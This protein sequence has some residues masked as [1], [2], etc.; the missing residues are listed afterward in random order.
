MKWGM[1]FV[2]LSSPTDDHFVKFFYRFTDHVLKKVM[3][4]RGKPS[5]RILVK[6]HCLIATNT[7]EKCYPGA[8]FFTTV[9]EPLGR[10]QSF[11]NFMTTLTI[12]GPPRNV[13]LASPVS[14]KV[15]RDYVVYTQIPYCEQEMLFYNQ[16]Q[17]NRLAIP[18]TM[19]VNNLSTTLQTVYNFCDVPMPQDLISNAIAMQY[20]THDR[21]KRKA[22]YDSRLNK[23]LESLGIDEVK[24]Q[25]TLTQ[26]IHWVDQLEEN[27]F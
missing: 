12:D 13:Y 25:E 14:W 27:A 10:F 23:S 11:I 7:L 26:Y 16:H 24:L 21:A 8:K 18:F 22:S 6:G 17:K 1:P 4:H 15:L 9:R 2:K 3:Y 19:F 20:S 5:Q